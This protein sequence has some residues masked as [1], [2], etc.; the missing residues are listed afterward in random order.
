ME[1]NDFYIGWQP[2]APVSYLKPVRRAIAFFFLLLACLAVSIALLQKK[3]SA[4]RFEFGSLTEVT[5]IYHSAPVPCLKV[6][7]KQ[8]ALGNTTY[9]TMPL[10]GYGKSGADGIIRELEQ[11]SEMNFEDRKV[12]FRGSLIYDDGK[13]LLQ[14]DKHDH[15][16]VKVS[17]VPVV[18]ERA[19][20]EL[21]E[22]ELT[23]EILDP[24]CY[25]GVMKPGHGKPHRDCAIRCVEGGIS[26]V[27]CVHN[28]KGQT[29]Y[30]LLLGS[31]G[32]KINDL[33]ADYIAEPVMLKARAVQ[34][35]DWIV[36]YLDRKQ[37]LKR[38]GGLSWFRND[39]TLSCG[40]VH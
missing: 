11:E 24:K 29:G 27:F 30:Y 3:F 39:G 26:P 5:G 19:V 32:E 7:S 20:R 6:I 4:G 37:P 9:I 18:P 34:Y 13:T 2:A 22:V 21:G 38:T 1:D 15:P 14:I 16:M 36:L 28:E 25:F 8:D 10:V 23:G 12:T 35:D 40:A 33:V 31:R 17:A